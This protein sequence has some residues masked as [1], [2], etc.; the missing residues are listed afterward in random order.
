MN[1][2]TR[3]VRVTR[4][5]TLNNFKRPLSVRHAFK[6]FSVK[7][8]PPLVE[9]VAHNPTTFDLKDVMSDIAT[10]ETVSLSLQVVLVLISMESKNMYKHNLRLGDPMSKKHDHGNPTDCE[11]VLTCYQDSEGETYCTLSEG[12][13]DVAP[14]EGDGN[15]WT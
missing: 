1:L 12:R 6:S 2:G 10:C 4:R 9:Y 11:C 3:F 15:L 8:V 14:D 5:V 7:V 13:C